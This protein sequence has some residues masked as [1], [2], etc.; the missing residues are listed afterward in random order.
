[1]MFKRKDSHS[2]NCVL[3][4]NASI[5][6]EPNVIITDGNAAANDVYVG[7]FSPS[8]GLQCLDKKMVFA[9]SWWSQNPYEMCRRRSAVCA[10]VLV[11]DHLSVS[12]ITCVYVSCEESSDKIKSILVMNKI[13][14]PVIINGKMF[15][16]E[17]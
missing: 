2:Q 11:W 13:D 15:F 9:R 17:A 3:G 4:I 8:P 16:Q 6:D 7:F 12:N 10:E 14:P 5:L 1:M